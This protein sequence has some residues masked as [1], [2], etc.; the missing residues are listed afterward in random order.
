[1]L[2]EC[3]LSGSETT[4]CLSYIMLLAM[5]FKGKLAEPPK[6]RPA[7]LP[8]GFGQVETDFGSPLEFD[9]PLTGDTSSA[10]TTIPS[11]V[12]SMEARGP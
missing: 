2:L 12:V 4:P 8:W 5:F 9:E 11:T 6:D 7:S 3:H 1:M 10:F